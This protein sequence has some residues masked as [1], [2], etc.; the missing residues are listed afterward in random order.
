MKRPNY[1]RVLK[2]ALQKLHKKTKKSF[3]MVYK[4]YMKALWQL[5]KS[6]IK[7]L[8]QFYKRFIKFLSK[9]FIK[10]LQNPFYV[11]RFLKEHVDIFHVNL[12]GCFVNFQNVIGWIFSKLVISWLWKKYEHVLG[13]WK[14][15][16]EMFL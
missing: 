4:S 8:W 12:I 14:C 2:K 3:R 6:F 5:Y 16:D 13:K 15:S 10:A 11:C 1:K 9:T 7:A